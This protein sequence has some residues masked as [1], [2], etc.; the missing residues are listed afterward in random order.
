M[1]DS[2][3]PWREQ[4]GSLVLGHLSQAEESSLRS[5]LDGCAECSRE[6]DQ[7]ASVAAV[8]PTA[9]RRRVVEPISPPP[10]ELEER[11][12]QRLAGERRRAELRLRRRM[13]VRI[14][15]GLAAAAIA[16]T[17]LV[18][19]TGDQSAPAPPGGV[20]MVAFESVPPGGEASAQLRPVPDG[21]EVE[22]QIRGMP[23]GDWVI[24]VERADGTEAQADAF[25]APS[26][27]WH[28]T[29]T[30]PVS[31]EDAVALKVRQVGGDA[32]LVA[33]LS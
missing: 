21:I 19:A 30:L 8:L 31:R 7:L 25:G 23:S 14:A 5:H 20:E 18:I 17:A 28:G 32:E 16:L 26:G 22:L 27:G 6:A 12:F 4:L 2:H 29:R 24:A 11:V 1:S 33:H 9:D 3:R 13:G 15:G 10:V